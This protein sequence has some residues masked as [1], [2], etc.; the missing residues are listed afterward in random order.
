MSKFIENSESVLTE[1][2]NTSKS[3]ENLRSTKQRLTP[4]HTELK[5]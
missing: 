5:L 3:L 4:E 2:R 1:A